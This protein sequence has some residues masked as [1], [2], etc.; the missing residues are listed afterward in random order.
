[1]PRQVAPRPKTALW[2]GMKARVRAARREPTPAEKKLWS[3]VRANKLGMKFRFQHPIDAFYVDFYC[4]EAGLAIELD[5]P[6]HD[7][8]TEEDH[9]RQLFFEANNIRVLRFTNDQV[10]KGLPNVIATIRHALT[11]GSA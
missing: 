5:G 3:V 9:A 6:I 1:M 4:V 11:E 2:D 10:F 7:R 8:Q